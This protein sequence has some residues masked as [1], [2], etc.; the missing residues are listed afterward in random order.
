VAVGERVDERNGADLGLDQLHGGRIVRRPLDFERQRPAF[1]VDR[2]GP[3]IPRLLHEALHHALHDH[4]PA[5]VEAAEQPAEVRRLG[6]RHRPPADD[7]GAAPADQGR[8]ATGDDAARDLHLVTQFGLAG[9]AG[10]IGGHASRDIDR[11]VFILDHEPVLVRPG[12]HAADDGKRLGGDLGGGEREHLGDR[13][14][15]LPR[16]SGGR[17][18]DGPCQCDRGDRG[19]CRVR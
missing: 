3:A 1:D 9:R 15:R 8:V 13:A 4:P 14:Q 18:T 5:D 6:R 16:R 7:A 10:I 12:H 17:G 11:R 19:P 2:Q